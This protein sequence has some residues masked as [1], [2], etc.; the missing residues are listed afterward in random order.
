MQPA[1]ECAGQTANTRR[2]FAVFAKFLAAEG[3]MTVGDILAGHSSDTM[4][5]LTTATEDE[6]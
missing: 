6:L 3:P 4:I 2:L 1:D 5:H